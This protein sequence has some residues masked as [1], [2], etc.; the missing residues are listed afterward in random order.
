MSIPFLKTPL[1]QLFWGSASYQ[2]TRVMKA[3]GRNWMTGKTVKRRLSAHTREFRSKPWTNPHQSTNSPPQRPTHD[4]K[5]KK[6][7]CWFFS[8]SYFAFEFFPPCVVWFH[9][10]CH[11]LLMQAVGLDWAQDPAFLC[12]DVL[13][14]MKPT[15]PSWRFSF[16]SE[17][18][19]QRFRQTWRET[20]QCHEDLKA[21]FSLPSP[22]GRWMR[23]VSVHGYR[24]AT[25]SW[26]HPQVSQEQSTSAGL[27]PHVR[28]HTQSTT[29]TP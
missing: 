9:T 21:N 23:S 10:A 5:K 19:Q 26:T 13:K 14:V 17:P 20:L 27:V 6:W 2:R 24:W 28:V 4:E 12:I 1:Q 29:N 7:T 3:G 25:M 16:L 15:E 18:V 22:V 11:L 8:V